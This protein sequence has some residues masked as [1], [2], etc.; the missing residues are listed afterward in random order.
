MQWTVP[1]RLG[2]KTHGMTALARGYYQGVKPVSYQQVDV[3]VEAVAQFFHLRLCHTQQAT[4]L[5]RFVSHMPGPITKTVMGPYGILRHVTAGL[6]RIEDAEDKAFC[7]A[8]LGSNLGDPQLAPVAQNFQ[9]AE[10]AVD[11]GNSVTLGLNHGGLPS[12]GLHASPI[13]RRLKKLKQRFAV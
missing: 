11:G 12:R 1:T 2:V 6:Q 4:L 5:G 3:F 13:S 9:H 7:H 8:E 10:G